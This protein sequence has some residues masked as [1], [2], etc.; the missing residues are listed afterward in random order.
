[1]G[2]FC[3]LNVLL[4]LLLNQRVK[5]GE[6]RERMDFCYVTKTTTTI[7]TA[8]STAAAHKGERRSNGASL[9]AKGN[10]LVVNIAEMGCKERR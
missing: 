1:M 9:L 6:I 2:I 7:T 10:A 4:L 8:A 3:L 5:I